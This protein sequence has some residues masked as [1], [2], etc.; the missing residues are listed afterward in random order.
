MS[1]SLVV[2]KRNSRVVFGRVCADTI[3]DEISMLVIE[4]K[5]KRQS[6]F[7]E[8]QER[9]EQSGVERIRCNS[10]L[11]PDW[12]QQRSESDSEMSSKQN[13]RG[14]I[15]THGSNGRLWTSKITYE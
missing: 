7:I 5:S 11:M 10:D 1:R 3:V 4:R 2:G 12:M 14:G 13:G 6:T 8:R 9:S 15:R